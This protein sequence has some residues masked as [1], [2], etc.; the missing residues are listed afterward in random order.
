MNPD[1]L[2]FTWTRTFPLNLLDEADANQ[3][4]LGTN[5]D[6]TRLKLLSFIEDPETELALM[7]KENLGKYSDG[8]LDGDPKP[9]PNNEN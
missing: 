8:G 2:E 6:A 5:S 9:D 4:L 7:E 3:K 1:R